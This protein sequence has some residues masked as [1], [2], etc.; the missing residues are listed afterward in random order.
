[1]DYQG[2]CFHPFLGCVKPKM[3]RPDRVK[4]T[5]FL[6]SFIS[7]GVSKNIPVEIQ[8]TDDIGPLK[9]SGF[10]KACD[11]VYKWWWRYICYACPI[12]TRV[13][14]GGQECIACSAGQLHWITISCLDQYVLCIW[15][16]YV[17]LWRMGVNDN[18]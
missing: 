3:P 11:Y 16:L 4:R 2:D 6:F 1:M 5:P 14:P 17:Y 13:K 12:G 9:G 10:S 15:T 7:H 8:S 18:G